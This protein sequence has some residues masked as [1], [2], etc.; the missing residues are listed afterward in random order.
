MLRLGHIDYSNCLP[1]HAALLEQRPAGV[2][3]IHGTPAELNEA[4]A[5]GEIDIAPASSIEY[6]R[7]PGRYRIVPGLSIGSFG[8]VQS[9]RL[10]SAVHIESLA[11]ARVAVPTASA[12][13]VVLLRIL[14]ELRYE[15]RVHYHWYA[16]G[17]D[18]DPLDESCA[19]ALRI[20]DIAL[21]RSVR[22][23]RLSYDLGELWTEWTG[24]PFAFALW[25][26]HLPEER[27]AE[28]DQLVQSLRA[29]KHDVL[30]QPLRLAVRYA[31][32]FG[33]P[34]D[35]LATYWTG[36]RYDLDDDMVGGLLHYYALAAQLGEIPSVPAL[37][38]LQVRNP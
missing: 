6:A 4:L 15:I 12:T 25:Q 11:N 1:V 22:P 32:H 17:D 8:P 2:E 24:L 19:A 5:R 14:L 37:R 31:A 28:L 18:I 7:H 20:G 3:I 27:N 30:T 16:Q 29:S 33:V 9:I 38:L 13:S 21:R 10:E 36:L 35:R 26:T 34:A 23:D